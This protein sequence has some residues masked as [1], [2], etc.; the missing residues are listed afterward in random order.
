MNMHLWN[1]GDGARHSHTCH[2]SDDIVVRLDNAGFIV[3]ASENAVQLGVD[4]DSL[5]LM[6]HVA[7][8]ADTGHGAQVAR[9]FE[10][11]MAGER[12]DEWL[13]FPVS[14]TEIEAGE[15]RRCQPGDVAYSSQRVHWYALNLRRVH[16]ASRRPLGAIGT[17]HSVQDKY[18]LD[19]QS[20][21]SSITDAVTGLA[22][23]RAFVSRLTRSLAL[24]DRASVATFA[25]DGMRAIFMQY[26]HGTADE[27][28]WGFARFLETMTEA[29][30]SLAQLDDERFA[31]LLPHMQPRAA[32][33][34]ADEIIR[35]FGGLAMTS[36][37]R[38]PEL[39]ASAGIARVELSV[40]WTL[41]QAELGLVMA[42]SAG[43]M[44]ASI[45]QT[46]IGLADGNSVERAMEAAV[47][48]AVSRYS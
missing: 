7:D 20:H 13:E 42:R 43:G 40:D 10:Q 46:S 28:R 27:I 22:N 41:R 44:Q 14:V 39:T 31:I 16:D 32:R 48:R 12:I 11:V 35:T 15:F 25:V 1:A 5:L 38:A 30:Q 18:E 8:F 29:G 9:Y 4:L 47:Q 17:L 33:E 36:G 3:N 6:P 24:S 23:R 37:N 21:V 45:C 2:H 19:R 34:W 26:G